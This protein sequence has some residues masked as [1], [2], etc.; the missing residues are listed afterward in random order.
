MPIDRTWW[1]NLV[2]DP[3]SGTVGTVWNKATIAGLLDAIDGLF[4]GP[5]NF[6]TALIASGGGSG[7]YSSSVILYQKTG[8]VVTI[9]GRVTLTS[10]GS[11]A[12]S[13]SLTL[14]YVGNTYHYQQG[15]LVVPYFSGVTIPIAQLSG[16]I[17][18]NANFV[19]LTYVPGGG[20]TAAT[21]ALDASQITGALDLMF[22]ATYLTN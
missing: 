20:S 15:V 9:A 11:L 6:T 18:Q 7:T 5:F 12:G 14:P 21:G 19:T 10:K 2:D 22:S 1:N 4:V 13:L 3:G 8:Q 17:N 16:Y